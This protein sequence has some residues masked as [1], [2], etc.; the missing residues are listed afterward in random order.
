MA[1]KCLFPFATTWET[2]HRISTN[3]RIGFKR[4]RPL[5]TMPKKSFV[6][7]FSKQVH[8]KRQKQKLMTDCMS[9]KKKS[10]TWKAKFLAVLVCLK[11]TGGKTLLWKLSPKHFKKAW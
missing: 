7:C 2:L 3:R 11:R 6:C 4:Q 1:Y 5:S 9:C 8:S 10:A